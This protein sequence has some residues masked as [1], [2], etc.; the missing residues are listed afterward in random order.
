MSLLSFAPSFESVMPVAED[1][2]SLAALSLRTIG[3]L[4]VIAGMLLLFRPLI[5][6]IW[7]AMLITVR[8]RRTLAQRAMQ[9]QKHA[10]V[11][12]QAAAHENSIIRQDLTPDLRQ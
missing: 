9:Q 6:G 4:G 8:P 12:P 5:I 2:L 1:A 3:G 7:H 11:G 10:S